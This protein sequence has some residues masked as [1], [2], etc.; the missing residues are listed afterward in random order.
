MT[1]NVSCSVAFLKNKK[2]YAKN[3]CQIAALTFA[4]MHFLIVA[5]QWVNQ[6]G[7]L[8]CSQLTCSVVGHTSACV[9][10]VIATRHANTHLQ[11]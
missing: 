1:Q 3:V 6:C 7:Q 8:I 9:Q 4:K 11:T 2:I 5:P 10:V